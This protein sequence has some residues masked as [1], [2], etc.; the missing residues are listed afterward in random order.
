MRLFFFYCCEALTPCNSST[1]LFICGPRSAREKHSQHKYGKKFKVCPQAERKCT[2]SHAGKYRVI[3]T[4]S[5][6]NQTPG[7]VQQSHLLELQTDREALDCPYRSGTSMCDVSIG[8]NVKRMLHY[9]L[10]SIIQHIIN[11]IPV[12]IYNI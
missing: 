4:D 5:K 1:T 6:S 8:V 12:V 10:L 9:S 7:P 3:K 11:K 2:G